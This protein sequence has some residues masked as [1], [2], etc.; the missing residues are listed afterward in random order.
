VSM[1]TSY[2]DPQTG[3]T[4]VLQ[5]SDNN[6]YY[7]KVIEAKVNS[8]NVMFR[9]MYLVYIYNICTY[10]IKIDIDLNQVPLLIAPMVVNKRP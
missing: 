7:G 10:E 9:D 4:F 6:Y 2:K 1:K 5:P 8:Q 3:D